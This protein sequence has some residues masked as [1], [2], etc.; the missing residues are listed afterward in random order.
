M[1][2]T[3]EEQIER[4]YRAALRAVDPVAATWEAF[5]AE[6]GEIELDGLRIGAFD[7]VVLVA[8]GKAAHAMA[9]GAREALGERIAAGIILTKD[10]LGGSCPAQFACFE[11]RHPIPDERGVEATRAILAAVRDL[12]AGDLLLALISGGGSALLEAPVPPL[13]LADIQETTRLLLRA[14]APIEDLN[15]VRSVLSEVKGGGL[16]RAAGDATVASLILSD[17]LGNDPRVIASGPTI[18][19]VPNPEEAR[20]LLSRYELLDAVPDAVR[21][22][23]ESRRKPAPPPPVQPARDV[24]HIVADNGTLI[25]AAAR[26]ADEALLGPRV[27]WRDKQGEAADLARAFVAAC[28]A[29]PAGVDCL[30]GGGEATVT[31]RG[32]GMGGRNTEFA[33]AAALELE[34]TGSAWHVASLAS[35]GDDASTGA[36][37]AIAG[38]AT[39]RNARAAGL[40]PVQ[41]LANNNSAHV[42]AVA[43]GLVTPGPTGTNVNDLYI[44]IR[45]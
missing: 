9:A 17:V 6:D 39:I 10:G 22:V 23:I 1:G 12:G 35:D 32:E 7:R 15:T 37:G 14:G 28:D 18:P 2:S 34:R 36:A 21:Q 40:D 19:S 27:I 43:G 25:D 24:W 8:I 3:P 26:A 20:R 13:T 4:I 16:R 5:R 44:A 45:G 41:E 33:L 38:A 31:V 30:I 11:A 29:L 42:F